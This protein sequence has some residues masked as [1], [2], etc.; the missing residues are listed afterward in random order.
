MDP[1]LS[2]IF[3]IN[4]LSGKWYE[5]PMARVSGTFVRDGKTETFDAGFLVVSD[6]TPDWVDIFALDITLPT[7]LMPIVM[8][9]DEREVFRQRIKA[10][11]NKN[12]CG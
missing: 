8:G 1:R 5:Y 12:M 4:I 11:V 10:W 3:D 2:P 6:G 9:G 7:N